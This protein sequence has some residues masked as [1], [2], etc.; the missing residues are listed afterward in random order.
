MLVK[1]TTIGPEPSS[2]LDRTPGVS[3][4]RSVDR[5]KHL[6]T[7]VSV[8]HGVADPLT[9][10]ALSGTKLQSPGRGLSGIVVVSVR[11]RPADARPAAAVAFGAVRR[12]R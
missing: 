2:Q 1:Y 10:P 9:S 5:S 11:T 8:L 3:S 6:K 4:I 12:I 7:M